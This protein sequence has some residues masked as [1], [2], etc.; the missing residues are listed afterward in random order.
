MSQNINHNPLESNPDQPAIK[1]RGQINNPEIH[2]LKLSTASHIKYDHENKDLY[3][4]W[5]D[6][7]QTD[8]KL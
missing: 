7:C 3:K 5:N 4:N 8:Y 6:I 1:E 2:I